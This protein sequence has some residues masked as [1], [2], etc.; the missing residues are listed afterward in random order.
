MSGPTVAV[1]VTKTPKWEVW[2]VWDLAKGQK[3]IFFRYFHVDHP[4]MNHYAS[5]HQIQANQIF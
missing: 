2:G 4:K 3:F 5:F 1:A